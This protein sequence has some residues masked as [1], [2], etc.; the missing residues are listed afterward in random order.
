MTEKRNDGMTEKVCALFFFLDRI[1][2]IYR[3]MLM[4]FFTAKGAKVYARGAME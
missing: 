4:F 1:N 3:I 2:R